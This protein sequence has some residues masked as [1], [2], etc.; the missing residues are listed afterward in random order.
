MRRSCPW[1]GPIDRIEVGTL[2]GLKQVNP[3]LAA[4]SG[5]QLRAVVRQIL[6]N[7]FR[8]ARDVST[9]TYRHGFGEWFISPNAD[10]RIVR[11]GV[12]RAVSFFS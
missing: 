1:P 11:P 4:A 9:G 10:F 6:P 8:I 7:D 12:K 3:S 5:R 2:S